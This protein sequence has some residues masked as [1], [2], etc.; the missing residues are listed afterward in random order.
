MAK[1]DWLKGLAGFGEGFVKTLQS[2]RER[3]QKELEFNQEMSYRTRQM[4]LMNQ[5]YIQRQELD[6]QQFGLKQEVL[7]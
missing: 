4:N 2:E 5:V 7:I 6:Q 1:T 3:K